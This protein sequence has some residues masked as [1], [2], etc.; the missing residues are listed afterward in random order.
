MSLKL[1][2]WGNPNDASVQGFTHPA[3]HRMSICLSLP[4]RF[5]AAISCNYFFKSNETQPAYL[6]CPT[7]MTSLLSN[8]AAFLIGY[9]LINLLAISMFWHDKQAA[10][11][12]LRR[13]SESNLLQVAFLGGSLGAILAN[14]WFHHKTHKQPFRRYLLLIAVFHTACV[15]GL[16]VWWVTTTIAR[17]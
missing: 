5:L 1:K 17:G 7:H 14:R 4:I 16:A 11:K 8:I 15:L 3:T 9:C 6:D 2:F 12:S 10:R 13:I